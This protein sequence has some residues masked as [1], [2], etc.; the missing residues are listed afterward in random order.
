MDDRPAQETLDAIGDLLMIGKEHG[1]GVTFTPDSEGW[2]VGYMRGMGGG[3][4]SSAVDLHTATVAA[5][6]PLL[7]LIRRSQENAR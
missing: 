7:E 3:D 6:R 1:V 4:L 5:Y 2:N